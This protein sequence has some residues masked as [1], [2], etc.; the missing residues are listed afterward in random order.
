MVEDTNRQPARL[1]GQIQVGLAGRDDRRLR[2]SMDNVPTAVAFA[3]SLRI[4]L[5]EQRA[6]TLLLQRV[7]PGIN[8]GMDVN[9]VAVDVHQR[10]ISDP[11]QV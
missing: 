3:A 1:P 10:Q 7:S 4:Q 11:L 6:L 2:G 5:P 9:P 8:G